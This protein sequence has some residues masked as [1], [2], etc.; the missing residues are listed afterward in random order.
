MGQNAAYIFFALVHLCN[1]CAQSQLIRRTCNQ[2]FFALIFKRVGASPT[3]NHNISSSRTRVE[4]HVYR[5]YTRRFITFKQ[6]FIRCYLPF[7]Y[8]F[9][10]RLFDI[11]YPLKQFKAVRL[12]ALLKM[13]L[14]TCRQ[15]RHIF[16]L[17]G[18][19]SQM[20]VQVSLQ[21]SYKSWTTNKSFSKYVLYQKRI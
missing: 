14:Q 21:T 16:L 5:R 7:D 11:S 2:S 8:Y 15:C 1:N 13:I 18:L 20:Y 6:A 19:T 17:I 4:I 3:P 12:A 9:R 10:K